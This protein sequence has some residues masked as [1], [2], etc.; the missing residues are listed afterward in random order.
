MLC[1][2][3]P[4]SVSLEKLKGGT[5]LKKT[6]VVFLCMLISSF[7]PFLTITAAANSGKEQVKIEDVTVSGTRGNYL[8][9]GKATTTGT[10]FYSVEDGH[11]EFIAN[12]KL[13]VSNN[14]F[15]LQIHIEEK[16]LPTNGTIII[17]F[18]EEGREPYSVVLETFS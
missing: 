1:K 8:V 18:S 13:Q 17:F 16:D 4:Y 11:N 5:I 2:Q 3:Q 14:Q 7:L 9:E 10:I 6:T 15:S 12:Q